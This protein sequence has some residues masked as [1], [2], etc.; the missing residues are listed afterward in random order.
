MSIIVFVQVV[1]RY[2]WDRFRMGGRSQYIVNDVD[3]FC[4]WY[5]LFY[6][7][8]NISI[9]I[10]IDKI[11]GTPKENVYIVLYIDIYFLMFI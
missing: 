5:L 3:C 9:T 4:R 2:I 6:D 8:S 1:L 10:L 7:K 11:Q